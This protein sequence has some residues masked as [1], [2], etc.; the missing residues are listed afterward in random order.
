[1]DQDVREPS[2]TSPAEAPVRSLVPHP[3]PSAGGRGVDSFPHLS[4]SERRFAFDAVRMS[5][6]G[7]PARKE[8][9]IPGCANLRLPRLVGERATRL[10]GRLRTRPVALPALTCAD[11]RERAA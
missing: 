7:L 3:G 5:E 8:G 9:I 6:R 4:T 10:H 1:L 11:A 2:R